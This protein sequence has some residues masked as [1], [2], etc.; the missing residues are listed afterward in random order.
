[1]NFLARAT[2]PLERR[3][4]LPDD[5]AVMSTPPA[6]PAVFV[7]RDRTLIEDPGYIADPA[8][9]QL[10]PGAAEAVALLRAAGYPV[11]VV[12]NQSGIARG[13]ITE[14][15]LAAVHQ[16][17]QALLQQQGTG[18]DAIYY[19]PYLDGPEAVVESYRRASS[20]RKPQPGMLLAAARELNLDLESS[21]MVG[22]SVS[23]IEA[24]RA[25]G[26]RTIRL[27]KP[28][29]DAVAD[30]YAE[31]L[32]AAARRILAEDHIAAEPLAAA[33]QPT[34]TPDLRR[35]DPKDPP[36]ASPQPLRTENAGPS[37]PAE[38]ASNTQWLCQIVEELRLLRRQQQH[39][40]FS[41]ARLA[42]AVAQAV[43]LCTIIYGLYAWATDNGPAATYGLLAGIAFQLMALSFFTASSKH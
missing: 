21:W 7:D 19:C 35:A 32:K 27:G 34:A 1:M 36:P 3:R 14:E 15:Q 13:L 38:S 22:D 40:D 17:L 41:I 31:D 2:T 18:V 5:P 16:R 28:G 42:A 25:A 37:G 11:V 6:R 24:G 43:A 20:L 10:L 33:P 4:L 12:T 8:Q 39:E 26:C 23:D 30:H 9:V 29:A